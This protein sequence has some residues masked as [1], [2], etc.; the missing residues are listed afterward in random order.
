[1][2]GNVRVLDTRVL[3]VLVA[4]CCVTGE[5]AD[6]A[7]RRPDGVGVLRASVEQAAAPDDLPPAFDW[8]DYGACTAIR[9]Q[10]C[11]DASWAFSAIAAVESAE[12]MTR[13]Q[14]AAWVREA[15]GL[16][17]GTAAEPHQSA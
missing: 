5:G 8:R 3:T 12:K 2:N 10:L 13:A 15:F 6:C 4:S 9:N 14:M 17:C 11:S 16:P 7:N 1:M